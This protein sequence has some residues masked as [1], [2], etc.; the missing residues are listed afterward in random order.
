M[1]TTQHAVKP[2]MPS[3]CNIDESRQPHEGANPGVLKGGGKG[4]EVSMKKWTDLL[5]CGQDFI[6]WDEGEGADN[7]VVASYTVFNQRLK[8]CLKV[9]LQFAVQFIYY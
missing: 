1:V 8:R 4:G 2:V 6:F 3:L 9:A 7:L 5:H